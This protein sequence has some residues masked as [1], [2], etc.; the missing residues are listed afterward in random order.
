MYK[1]ARAFWVFAMGFMR[2]EIEET[3]M[4][5]TLKFRRRGAEETKRVGESLAHTNK[6]QSY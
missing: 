3:K 6:Q 5:I 4:R 1:D 2:G